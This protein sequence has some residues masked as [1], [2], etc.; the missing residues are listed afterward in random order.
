M[1]FLRRGDRIQLTQ[2]KII[3]AME[4]TK[5]KTEFLGWTDAAKNITF[6]R[7][8]PTWIWSRDYP[9]HTTQHRNLSIRNDEYIHIIVLLLQYLTLPN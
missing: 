6:L 3:E 8:F 4:N 5:Q 1:L 7:A 9:N 2:E